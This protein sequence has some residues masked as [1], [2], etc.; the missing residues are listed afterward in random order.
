MT[1]ADE[2]PARILDAAGYIKTRQDHVRR[3]LH[4]RV[5]KFS[6]VDSGIFGTFIVNCDR[7]GICV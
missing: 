2:L 4:T 7:F 3:I 5:A 1:K 6:E